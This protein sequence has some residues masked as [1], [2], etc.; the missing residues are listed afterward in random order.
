LAGLTVGRGGNGGGRKHAGDRGD[1][2]SGV[3]ERCEKEG[4][5]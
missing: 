5:I 3:D 4:G 2:V 1:S